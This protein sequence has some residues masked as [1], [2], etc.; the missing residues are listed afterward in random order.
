LLPSLSS[1]VLQSYTEVIPQR[2]TDFPP[3]GPGAVGGAG[4]GKSVFAYHNY[5]P[6]GSDGS[7]TD[8]ALCR[9]L[10]HA[11][12][13][14]VVRNLDHLGPTVGGML[15]EF[16]AVGESEQDLELLDLQAASADQ[17]LQG[18]AYWT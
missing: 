17:L 13:A 1:Q 8:W 12:W 10:V 15:T 3:G 4:D 2:T 9:E 11:N 5:C 18:W 16:G 7:V 14:G 6:S